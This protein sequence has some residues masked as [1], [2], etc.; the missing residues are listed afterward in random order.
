[1][2]NNTDGG[3]HMDLISRFLVQYEPYYSVEGKKKRELFVN[4]YTDDAI[5]DLSQREYQFSGYSDTFCYSMVQGLRILSSIGNAFPAIYGVYVDADQTLKMSKRLEQKFGD[6]F[7]AALNYQK[8]QIVTL[9]NA[10]KSQDY[11]SIEGSDI[12]SQFRFKILSV[13]CP[14]MYFPVCT[15]PTA[16]AYCEV[17]GISYYGNASML[18]LNLLLVDWSRKNLPEDWDLNKAMRFSDWL[19]REQKTL[20]SSNKQLS[21][22]PLYRKSTAPQK[23]PAESQAVIPTKKAPVADKKITDDECLAMF[24]IGCRVSHNKFGEGVVKSVSEGVIIIEFDGEDK[25]LGADFCV[26][27]KI[28]NRL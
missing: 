20:S 25:K 23:K 10:A 11:R 12:N 6:N 18:D 16:E 13:Y 4:K 24:P 3:R 2:S 21:P 9:I 17:F 27:N 22:K 26:K 19:W 1:M 14:E 5:L 15:R 7:D 28:L 8:S